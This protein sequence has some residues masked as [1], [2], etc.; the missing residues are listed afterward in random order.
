MKIRLTFPQ[1]ILPQLQARL[2][3]LDVEEVEKEELKGNQLIRTYNIEP[4]KYRDINQA[5]KKL[6]QVVVEVLVGVIVN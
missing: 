3:E 1:D 6:D 4:N 2:Q 5:C